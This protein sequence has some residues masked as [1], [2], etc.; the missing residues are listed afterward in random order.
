MKPILLLLLCLL[1]GCASLPPPKN[2]ANLCAVF[3]EKDGWYAHARA[4][5]QHWGVPIAVQMAFIQQES[6]FVENARPPRYRFLG[7]IPLWRKSS[8]Y[9]YGQVKDETWDW[10]RSQ[11]GRDG[12]DRDDFAD[13]TDFIG[14]Y[15][16]ESHRQLGIP[17][18]DAYRQY[19]AYHEGHQGYRLG[20][21]NSKAWLLDT[22]RRV[23]ASAGRYR[24]QLLGCEAQLE[25]ALASRD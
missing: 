6:S 4:A 12:A 10:Y 20:N 24:S 15:V 5:R 13:A 1:A 16:Q 9:G 7:F 14:W 2:P 19:L 8:A 25:R 3:Q 21:Y 18:Q 11:T 22:A 17:K 23:A